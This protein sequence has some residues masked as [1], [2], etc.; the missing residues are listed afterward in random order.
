MA[1]SMGFSLLASL[2]EQKTGQ[3]WARL[4]AQGELVLG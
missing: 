3:V 2:Y 1:E 4:T